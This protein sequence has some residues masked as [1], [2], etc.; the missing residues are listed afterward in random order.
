[1]MKQ[2]HLHL[3]LICALVLGGC[4]YR[5]LYGT[6]NEDRGVVGELASVAIP[7]ADTRLGQLIRNDLLSGMRPAGTAAP[8]R[9]RLDM[10]IDRDRLNIIDK[11]QPNVTRNAVKV[12]VAFT[13]VDGKTQVYSG[14]TFSQVSYDVVRQPFA[15][16]QAE[17]NAVE[18][19][20]HELSA[21]IK[22]RLAAYFATH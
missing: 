8:D 6:T 4:S 22:T 20:A 17:N 12:S 3:A 10:D 2:S 14:K 18:R 11:K 21:D 13:L 15:D 5:P 19:V 1:M 16:M 9:Y 7:E